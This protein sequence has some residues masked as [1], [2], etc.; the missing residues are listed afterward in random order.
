M[1]ERLQA[2]DLKQIATVEAIFV[3]N[4]A[5]R[6]Q[7]MPRKPLPQPDLEEKKRAPIEGIFP[8]AVPV[9]GEKESSGNGCGGPGELMILN[10]RERIGLIAALLVFVIRG[11]FR[12]RQLSASE[13]QSQTREGQHL[14]DGNCALIKSTRLL[15][16][17]LKAA[18]ADS[19]PRREIWSFF[20]G[21]EVPGWRRG[22]L[23]QIA[24]A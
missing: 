18:F 22:C 5:Q 11:H 17:S 24:I 9:E 10:M 15:P 19:P 3:Y 20:T 21:R 14:L 6:D 13:A 23:S 1:L 12:T 2:A 7:M 16:D 4:A 8:G